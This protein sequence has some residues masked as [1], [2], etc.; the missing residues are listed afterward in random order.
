MGV[1]IFF[2]CSGFR[3]RYYLKSLF[4]LWPLDH[5]LKRAPAKGDHL[6]TFTSKNFD[7]VTKKPLMVKG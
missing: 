7:A 6:A 4:M 5:D 1:G 3:P 2:L